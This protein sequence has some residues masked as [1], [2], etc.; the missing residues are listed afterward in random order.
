[1]KILSD[2]FKNWADNLWSEYLGVWLVW[3]GMVTWLF[4]LPVI[5]ILYLSGII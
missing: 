4:V 3:L 5:G 2:E 1:M